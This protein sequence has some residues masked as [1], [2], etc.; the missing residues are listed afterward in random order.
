[1]TLTTHAIAGAA[2]ASAMPSHPV[3]GFVAGFASHYLLDAIPHW[4]YELRSTT[5]NPNDPMDESITL[6]K[7]F[8]FDLLKMGFDAFLGIAV[9]FL[10]FGFPDFNF[11]AIFYSAIIWGIIGGLLPD[12][13]QFVYLKCKHEPMIGLQK[14]HILAHSKIKMDNRPVLGIFSQIII[15][16]LIA[17]VFKFLV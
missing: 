17:A 11:H 7:N 12:A 3:L 1:M 13:L 4:E 16:A 6:D 15:I 10:F 5:E 8:I 14:F 9:A 2:V